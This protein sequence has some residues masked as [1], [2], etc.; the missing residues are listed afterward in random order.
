[1]ILM[2]LFS[3]PDHCPRGLYAIMPHSS[4]VCWHHLYFMGL[5]GQWV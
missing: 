5:D 3:Q 4:S 1:M 2:I